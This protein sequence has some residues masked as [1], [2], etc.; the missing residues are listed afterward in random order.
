LISSV[1]GRE[2]LPVKEAILDGRYLLSTARNGTSRF[3]L[4]GLLIGAVVAPD[5]YW[6]TRRL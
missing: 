1:T 2:E 4:A 6:P 3:S 5:P